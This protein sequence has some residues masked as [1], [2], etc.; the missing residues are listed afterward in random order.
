MSK[1]E[2]QPKELENGGRAGLRCKVT[3]SERELMIGYGH[4]KQADGWLQPNGLV[5]LEFL[6]D[7]ND[8]S[9]DFDYLLVPVSACS[10]MAVYKDQG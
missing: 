6:A 7:R 4:P 1:P 9:R 10:S 8:N 3:L 2:V 5:R